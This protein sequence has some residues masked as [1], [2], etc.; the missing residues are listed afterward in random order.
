MMDYP[1]IPCPLVFFCTFVK[2]MQ[3]CYSG[4]TSLTVFLLW[5]FSTNHTHYVCDRL[6]TFPSALFLHAL[7]SRLSLPKIL[8]Q[9]QFPKL[10][11]VK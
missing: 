6:T 2:Q 3:G 11:G 5:T 10:S 4:S 1:R 9:Q 8:H 7:I